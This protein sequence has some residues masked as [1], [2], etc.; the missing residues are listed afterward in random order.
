VVGLSIGFT[1]V[2]AL[3]IGPDRVLPQGMF[4]C[5]ALPASGF[6]RAG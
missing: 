2:P 1:S 5:M 3:K 6:L 4:A